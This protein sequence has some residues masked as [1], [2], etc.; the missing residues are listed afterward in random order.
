MLVCIQNYLSL[1]DCILKIKTTALTDITFLQIGGWLLT[2][3]FAFGV[4]FMVVTHLLGRHQWR[5]Y[6][7]RLAEEDQNRVF[8]DPKFMKYTQNGWRQ[9]VYDIS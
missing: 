9:I 2:A 1:K 6:Q 8:V 3:I 4:I 5:K 7:E